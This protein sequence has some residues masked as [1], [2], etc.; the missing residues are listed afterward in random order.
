MGW[1]ARGR[2]SAARLAL[3]EAERDGLAVQI[4]EVLDREGRGVEADEIVL[5]TARR[6]GA[7][8][9]E[10]DPVARRLLLLGVDP[11]EPAPSADPGG[12]TPSVTP[13][14]VETSA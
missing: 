4:R 11:D 9:R 5:A 13:S 8:A 3:L 14:R 1:A 6:A 10:S 12:P 7:A 2:V